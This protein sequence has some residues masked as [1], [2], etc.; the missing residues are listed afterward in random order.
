MKKVLFIADAMGPGEFVAPVVL[1]ARKRYEVK[2]LA[3]GKAVEV[4]KAVGGEE[5]KKMNR[6]LLLS[7]RSFGLIF[8]RRP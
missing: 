8:S 2:T 7:T 5:I 1:L 6:K 4:L 3:F